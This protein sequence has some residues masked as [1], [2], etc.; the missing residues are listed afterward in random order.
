MDLLRLL[1]T[2]PTRRINC[3]RCGRRRGALIACISRGTRAAGS[4]TQSARI[5]ATC[6]VLSARA[7]TGANL[8][9]VRGGR[10]DAASEVK[11]QEHVV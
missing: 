10:Q 5:R 6:W 8:L 11:L 7:R 9:A 2:A 3:A 1:P 4:P